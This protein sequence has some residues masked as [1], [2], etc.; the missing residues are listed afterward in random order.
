MKAWRKSVAMDNDS[1]NG[2]DCHEYHRGGGSGGEPG[3]WGSWLFGGGG[4]GESMGLYMYWTAA[5]GC[6]AGVGFAAG[7]V[8]QHQQR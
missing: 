4:W 7:R 3:G 5:L 1:A 6:A 2:A 8:M